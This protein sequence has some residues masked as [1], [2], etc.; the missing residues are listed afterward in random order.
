MNVGPI[1]RSMRHNRTRV[2]LV[3]LEIAMTLAIV[4]NCVDV[5]LAERAKMDQRS[6][7]DD[8]N[9]VHLY[10]RPFSQEFKDEQVLGRIIP[11]DLK[12]IAAVPGVKAVANTSFQLWEG[13]GSSTGVKPLGE[14][15]EPVSTQTYF[16]SEGIMDALGVHIVEGRAFQAS[17]YGR[18][19]E[20]RPARVAIVSK[21]LADDLFP[22]QSAVGKSIQQASDAT[23]GIEEGRTIVG[24]MEAFFNPWGIGAGNGD[25][26]GPRAM[27]EP[28]YIGSYERGMIYLIRTEPGATSSVVAE[29]EKR[30]AAANGGRVFE[31]LSVPEKKARWFAPNK[32]AVTT[33]TCIIVVLVLV[34]ALGLLGLTS[35]SVAERTRQIGV[36]RALGATRGDIVAHFL[37]ENGLITAAGLVLGVASAYGLNVLLVSQVS[38]V[39]LTWP[40]VAAGVGL[41]AINGV[42]A[43]LPAALRA[44]LVPP[45]SATRTV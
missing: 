1:L 15:K 2:V 26:L 31:F 40:L 35:L 17:D 24:V 41:L 6:G 11:Q 30:L 44:S 45:S 43:T 22:G 25:L 4:T 13:G 7:F 10:E 14:V 34:T 42:L 27:F 18:P 37:L 3:V 33:M 5:I 36:R 23:H 12:T 21:A 9:I 16:G 32:I 28:S 8:D 20:P 19:G 29:V 39:K 38:D